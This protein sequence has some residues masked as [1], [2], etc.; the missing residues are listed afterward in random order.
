M[1]GRLGFNMN[2]LLTIWS[3]YVT[4]PLVPLTQHSGGPL[5]RQC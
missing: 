1:I 4:A 3:R 5:H 2:Q